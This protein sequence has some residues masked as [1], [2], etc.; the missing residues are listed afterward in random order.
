MTQK[1]TRRAAAKLLRLGLTTLQR[2]ESTTRG[3]GLALSPGLFEAWLSA[4][5]MEQD[6]VLFR[7][8]VVLKELLPDSSSVFIA[9][10]EIWDDIDELVLAANRTP[11]EPPGVVVIGD[12]RYVMWPSR[13]TW[14][15][16]WEPDRV[17]SSSVVERSLRITT[18]IHLAAF[19][20]PLEP[21][22]DI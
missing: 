2:L 16:L 18:A 20:H 22:V 17:Q 13:R 3:S 8:F 1:L 5:Y 15:D 11:D 9:L 10:R 14:L 4:E 7:L 12:S 19:L 21:P 6:N